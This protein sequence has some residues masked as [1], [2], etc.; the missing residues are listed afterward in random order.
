MV[1][2]CVTRRSGALL[3]CGVVYARLDFGKQHK[4]II[5]RQSTACFSVRL[6]CAGSGRWAPTTTY[7]T[8]LIPPTIRPTDGTY[9][10]YPCFCSK[11]TRTS[12]VQ[13]DLSDAWAG[14]GMDLGIMF[15]GRCRVTSTLLVL[16]THH[17][18]ASTRTRTRTRKKGHHHA[19]DLHL[20]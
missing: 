15:I 5:W 19:I 2:L 14:G 8:V 11:S 10:T 20:Q 4:R 6:C 9:C 18:H 12:T 3:R 16:R 7:T 1:R 13:Y 17:Y